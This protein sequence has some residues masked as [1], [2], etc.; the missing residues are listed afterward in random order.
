MMGLGSS[1]ESL[2]TIFIDDP[3]FNTIGLMEETLKNMMIG[4][5]FFL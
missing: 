4:M 3:Y 5:R 2:C 1:I